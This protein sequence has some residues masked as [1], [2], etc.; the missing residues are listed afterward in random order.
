MKKYT[1][2]IM[3]VLLLT[4]SASAQLT[5]MWERQTDGPYSAEQFEGTCPDGEGGIIAVGKQWNTDTDNFD[6]V[7]ARFNAQGELLWRNVHSGGEMYSRQFEDVA[8]VNYYNDYFIAVGSTTI[9]SDT[10]FLITAFNHDGQLSSSAGWDFAGGGWLHD[11]RWTLWGL[12]ACGTTELDN[13]QQQG[14]IMRINNPLDIGW[15][16]T[17][18]TYE[19]NFLDAIEAAGSGYIA[20]GWGWSGDDRAPWILRVDLS[21]DVEWSNYYPAYDGAYPESLI[22]TYG[23][24]YMIAGY[25]VISGN[26]QYFVMRFDPDGNEVWWNEYG[27]VD[28]NEHGKWIG[29][30]SQSGYWVIG[31]GFSNQTI[32]RDM[33]AI[34]INDNGAVLDSQIFARA[35]YQNVWGGTT[36]E[37]SDIVV[38]GYQEANSPGNDKCWVER[39][40]PTQDLEVYITP[41]APPIVIPY[42]GGTF[43]YKARGVNNTNSPM[44]VEA[45]MQIEHLDSDFSVTVRVFENVNLPANS[46]I[47]AL[48]YQ[49]VPLEAPQGEFRMKLLVGD[50]PWVVQASDWFTFTKV[51]PTLATGTVNGSVFERSEL[52]PS[53]GSFGADAEAVVSVNDSNLPGEFALGAAYPNP[54]NPTTTVSVSLPEASDL[55]VAVY[56]TIGQQVAELAQGRVAA[57]THAYTFD[58]S[59]LS[60][61]VYF[62][63]A[64]VPGQLNAMQKVVL[65]K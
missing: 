41:I 56:N 49:T 59:A 58:A 39:L 1:V 54:F 33:W 8:P 40:T 35:G 30:T 65:M 5:S 43:Q 9:G 14:I 45:W 21:G 2:A 24:D 26:S 22:Q 25:S 48:L 44:Q 46:D 53:T 57:G 38:V 61:G 63:R 6:A 64:T 23:A 42:P 10:H 16:Q 28:G 12:I 19:R 13:D 3:V 20:T 31:D 27:A 52:W 18:G 60:S 29:K 32:D 55:T 51:G 62:V 34:R 7:Y 36:F 37:D 17:Y 47:Q 11:I 4:V 15:W 50:H